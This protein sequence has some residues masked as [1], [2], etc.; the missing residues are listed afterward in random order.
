MGAQFGVCLREESASGGSTV[1]TL[2]SF[3]FSVKGLQMKQ[4]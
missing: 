1:F 3:Y 2:V 4:I